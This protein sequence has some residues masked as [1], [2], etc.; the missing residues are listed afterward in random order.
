VPA[1]GGDADII[2][3]DL[4]VPERDP[5]S[6]SIFP[7]SD[8]T[9]IE[10]LGDNPY[11][12]L[13]GVLGQEKTMETHFVMAKS[14]SYTRSASEEGLAEYRKTIEMAR[15][16][17]SEDVLKEIY[18]Q[19]IK[20]LVNIQ[21]VVSY[22]DAKK[23][24]E[25]YMKL[26]PSNPKVLACHGVVCLE[27]KDND[28]AI[29]AFRRSLE[30]K[31]RDHEVGFALIRT[32]F[33]MKDYEGI[34]RLIEHYGYVTVG[35]WLCDGIS[36]MQMHQFI[37]YA[38]RTTTN[39][40]DLM[41]KCYEHQIENAQFRYREEDLEAGKDIDPET[42]ARHALKCRTTN[43]AISSMFRVYLGW[44]Y[45]VFLGQPEEAFK[46]WKVAFFHRS[47]FFNLRNMLI[48][49][50]SDDIIPEFFALF[51][52]QIY[53]RAIAPDP[54]VADGMLSLLESLQR[55][56]RGFQALN[57]DAPADLK[58]MNLLLAKLYL[59]LGRRDEARKMLDEQFQ[60]AVEILQDE[61]GWNDCSG[62]DAL[63][64]L[65]YLNG[66]MENAEIA[67]SLKR[68][69]DSGFERKDGG[70]IIT[71]TNWMWM[72]SSSYSCELGSED[73]ILAT[74]YTCTTCV[75]VQF[76]EG[77][78]DN[79]RNKTGKE[80]LYICNPSHDFLKSPPEG[81]E[82][83]KDETITINGKTVSFASWLEEVRREWKMGD[84]F[85]S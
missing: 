32:L 56:E 71:G 51:S 50:F 49:T 72:C 48:S 82:K 10:F 45:D 44:F 23:V 65:L 68:F 46:L 70:A 67:L 59:R 28:G 61:V 18:L 63:T 41:I 30:M 75:N 11:N 69:F 16:K 34:M 40:L 54:E 66:Q 26:D 9:R 2:A 55:R 13:A 81:L 1:E 52:Q 29:G 27:N 85:K 4:F 36:H 43:I 78:Y 37:M 14:I 64:R 53:D 15:Q 39:R 17:G 6:D 7:E 12:F 38:A 84:C 57:D 77:C 80:R 3:D 22:G 19:Q 8:S 5:E 79:L 73:V 35:S 60:R 83:I 33:T 20:A 31:E 42:K 47:E 62:Y 24:I 76:C 21:T 25:D 74:T 58:N